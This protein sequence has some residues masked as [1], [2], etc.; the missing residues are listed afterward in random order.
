MHLDTTNGLEKMLVRTWSKLPKYNYLMF[1][2]HQLEST[3][4][5]HQ[6]L[7]Y[8]ELRKEFPQ[9]FM[10]PSG[11]PP[12]RDVNHTILLKMEVNVVNI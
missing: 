9:V 5:I 7:G 8:K 4:N 1:K 10:K 6:P 12:K 3:E 2:L 11:L